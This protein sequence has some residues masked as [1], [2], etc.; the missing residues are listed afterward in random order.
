MHCKI[1]H[2]VSCHNYEL[3]VKTYD[4]YQYR[5]QKS[6]FGEAVSLSL[7]LIPSVP[8]EPACCGCVVKLNMR[9]KEVS[10][11]D[12]K[13]IKFGQINNFVHSNKEGSHWHAQQHQK[14]LKRPRTKTKVD[15]FLPS[16]SQHPGKPRT[17]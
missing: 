13:N 2:L 12:N 3:C 8:S 5:P 9:S 7:E 6:S 14:T 15:E 10:I 11:S 4:Q 17:L 16:N 1:V